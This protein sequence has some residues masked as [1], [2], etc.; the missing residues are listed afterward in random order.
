MWNVYF[1][2]RIGGSKNLSEV[3]IRKFSGFHNLE[4]KK[5]N[6]VYLGIFKK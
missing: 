5:I 3:S 6:T 2:L 1:E 4:G